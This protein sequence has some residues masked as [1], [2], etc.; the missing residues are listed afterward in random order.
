MQKRSKYRKHLIQSEKSFT[1]VKDW[2]RKNPSK[3]RHIEGVPTTFQ[4]ADVLLKEGYTR[5]LNNDWV[6]YTK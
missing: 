1:K 3:F 6:V 5:E 2:M 4:I